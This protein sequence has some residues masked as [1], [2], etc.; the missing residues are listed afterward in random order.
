VK[1]KGFTFIQLVLALFILGLSLTP[2]VMITMQGNRNLRE[3]ILYL[4]ALMTA[5]TVI[6]QAKQYSFIHKNL[7]KTINVG[8]E[9]NKGFIL[10]EE[11]FSRTKA[12]VDIIFKKMDEN[13]VYILVRIK[14]EGKNGK[15]REILME[16]GV[17]PH[18][19]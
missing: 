7:G 12:S 5:T 4:D 15:D 17:F 18:V 3:N 2:V 10:P 16:S 6:S 1:K 8:L 19:R 9:D 13:L 11:L 14:Y